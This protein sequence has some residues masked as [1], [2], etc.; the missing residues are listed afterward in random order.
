MLH[1]L[2]FENTS[3]HHREKLVDIRQNTGMLKGS[4]L[5]IYGPESRHERGPCF[6]I[7]AKWSVLGLSADVGRTMT[8][9]AVRI[10]RIMS[11]SFIVS[12]IHAG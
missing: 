4:L 11:Y 10:N 6:G 12:L 5:G 9:C 7:E 3:L 2:L 1:T 8:E